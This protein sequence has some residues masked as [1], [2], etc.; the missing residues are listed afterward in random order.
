M[1]RGKDDGD[2]VCCE[3]G[4]PDSVCS[5]LVVLVTIGS[6]GDSGGKVWCW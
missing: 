3:R 1:R 2:G 4:S 6:R 5:V